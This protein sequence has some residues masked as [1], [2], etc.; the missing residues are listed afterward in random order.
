ME[1]SWRRRYNHIV[2][3]N[4]YKEF[5]EEKARVGKNKYI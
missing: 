5:R 3:D 4:E 2:R 1:E